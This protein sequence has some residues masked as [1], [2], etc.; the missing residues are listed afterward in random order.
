MG[1]VA[2]QA[3]RRDERPFLPALRQ[4]RLRRRQGERMP[5]DAAGRARAFG[6]QR[7]AR[8]AL[9]ST[10]PAGLAPRVALVRARYD[11]AG[12]AERFVQESLALL[13]AQGASVTLL[14]RRWPGG[15]GS[16]L[17]V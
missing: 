3:P 13:R 9:M 7:T 11:P 1:A 17:R 12:G 14:A 10:R 5:H 16:V 8:L 2:R 15:E 4:R 6:D